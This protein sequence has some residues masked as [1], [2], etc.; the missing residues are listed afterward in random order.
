V[1]LPNIHYYQASSTRHKEKFPALIKFGVEKR[2]SDDKKEKEETNGKVFSFPKIDRKENGLNSPKN[3]RVHH[4]PAQRMGCVSIH[5][6][7][8]QASS[9]PCCC[10]SKSL[11][12]LWW[13]HGSAFT[14]LV[15]LIICLYSLL[16]K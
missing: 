3:T 15:P 8:N 14:I 12:L 1:I 5:S 10:L 4:M 13:P 7:H 2:G 11:S 9:Y 16:R 6:K